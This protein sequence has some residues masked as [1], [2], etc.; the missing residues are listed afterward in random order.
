MK[1]VVV[2][3]GPTGVGKTKISIELAQY[4][5]G[6]IINA[7]ASQMHKDLNIGTAK[8][9]KEEMKGIVHYLIDWIQPTETYTI[10]N[11]QDDG[12]KIIDSLDKLPFIVGGSGLYIQSLISNYDLSTK[13]RE[14]H[15]EWDSLTNEELYRKLN[16][17]QPSMAL[18]THPNNR[19]R[20]TRYLELASSNNSR[21]S[22][23][24]S[25]YY[26]AFI[27]CL[28]RNREEL[29][30]RI[31]DR[32]DEMFQNGWINE[33]MCL[34]KNGIDL[35]KIKEIGYQEIAQYIEEGI[36]NDEQLNLL[37]NRIKQK[38]RNYA[39]RQMTWFHHQMNCQFLNLSTMNFDESLE[40]SKEFITCFLNQRI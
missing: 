23:P 8:I 39:K 5:H 15:P 25:P 16:I 12:R 27:L 17:L 18:K 1:K 37:K 3:T 22:K 21:N 34:M 7:D 4:F 36:M 30:Q 32:C 35:K 40:K 10:K 24:S 38:T 9:T 2:V 33:C 20:V 28:I 11:F 26:D 19:R 6:E 31:N 13:S 29:Y 14:E